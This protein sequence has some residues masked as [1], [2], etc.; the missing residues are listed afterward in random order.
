MARFARLIA[1]A[2]PLLYLS[3]ANCTRAEGQPD[4]E[5]ET[6]IGINKEP[7]RVFSVP[8]GTRDEAKSAA[9]RESSQ[10]RLLNGAWKFRYSKRPEDR[11]AEFYRT[12]FDTSDW[13]DIQVPG[14][15]QTQGYG[16]PIYTNI[17]YPFKRDWP[18]VTGEP[19]HDWTAFEARNP[20][21]SYVRQFELPDAWHDD[22]VFIHFAGVES[23]FYLWINGQRVGY[24]QGSYTPAEF[25]IGKYLRPGV[26]T[27]AVEVYRWCDGSYLEDQDFW[28][29]SGIFRDVFLYRTPEVRLQDYRLRYDFDAPLKD[30]ALALDATVQN[31]AKVQ[32]TAKITAEL[33]DADGTVVWKAQ[34]PEIE[35][36]P[37]EHRAVTLEGQLKDVKKWTGE[38]PNRYQL[39]ITLTDRNGNE[40]VAHRHT[41]GFRKIEF[42]DRG[43]LLVNGKPVIIKGVNRHEH[44][45]DR[46]R[47]VSAE[48][49]LR[50]IELFKQLNVNAVR[51]SHYPNHPDWYEL[52][53]RY[54]IYVIDEANIESH[55]YGYGRESLA[56]VPSYKQAHVDRCQRMVLRDRN[57]PSIVFWSLGNEAG[58]GENFVAAAKRVRELDDT[59][60]V[61][62]ERA[63]F[64]AEST[65]MDSVMYPA[66]DWLLERGREDNSRPFFMCEYAHA[67]GNAI[68]NLDEYLQA[69]EEHPRLIGGC[70]WDWVDQGLR[71]PNPNG[72][73]A[74]NGRADFFAYGG[75]FG[76]RPNDSNFCI[77]GVVTPDRTVTAKSLQVKHSYQPARIE[78]SDGALTIRNEFSHTDLRDRCEL[79]WTVSRDGD[80][81]AAGVAALPSIAPWS[82][83]QIPLDLPDLPP[84]PGSDLRLGVRLQLR[85]DQA[86]LPKGHVVA[87]EQFQLPSPAKSEIDPAQLASV[88]VTQSTENKGEVQVAGEGFT[89]TVSASGQLSELVYAGRTVFAGEAGFVPN[90]YRAP[91]DNDGPFRGVWRTA[92]LERLVPSDGESMRSSVRIT[93]QTDHL[94]Q[95]TVDRRDG[96]EGFY[97]DSSIAY[98]FLGDG[99]LLVDAVVSPSDDA[100]VLPRVGLTATLDASLSR[101]AYY[102]RGPAENYRDRKTGQVIGRY[103]TD[104]EDFYEDYVRPQSMGNRCDVQWVALRNQQGDGVLI[105][106]MSPLSF[107]ALRFTEQALNA[108][109]HDYGLAESEGVVLSLDGAHTGLGGASC[110]P[111][112]L[113]QYTHRGPAR[114]R[115]CV[116]PLQR[117]DDPAIKARST[118]AVGP[119]A[120]FTRSP[121]GQLQFDDASP[122]DVAVAI[123]GQSVERSPAGLEIGE[124]GSVTASPVT[125]DVDS[126]PAV[127]T[128]RMLARTFDRSAW[129]VSVS[130]DDTDGPAADLI[131]G[132]P[133]TFW[134]SRW[135]NDSP[136]PPHEAV[137][138]FG[139]PFR[140]SG[141]KVAPRLN[142]SNGRVR[143]YRIEAS[144]D[145]NSWRTVATGE[146]AD[147]EEPSLISFS[148]E[149]EVRFLRFVA[150]SSY[151]G[152]WASMAE[153]EPVISGKHSPSTPGSSN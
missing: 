5:N 112:P 4:W 123:D 18:Q 132:N 58:F 67:M 30:V 78:F 38:S 95:V 37:G 135:R 77:N 121:G 105:D 52:C 84:V 107:T 17:T 110:G 129:T 114:V 53:D 126:I 27:I 59:R 73:L 63:P 103:E 54:G 19:P 11:P 80:E 48:L 10:V 55:G 72:R 45:P 106:A 75:D 130:S 122:S 25:Q 41:V 90:L 88:R 50:D 36:Q 81:V 62:Y 76:D 144:E 8:Y 137:I 69:V 28:R 98:T 16:T 44:D 120:L 9:W 57:H 94:V 12:D 15:W 111:P 70:I 14:N 124:G 49:M 86:P 23:A 43:E 140:L 108:A 141:V 92:G 64:G 31:L 127:A 119:S 128:T 47:T 7:G 82:T 85:E 113:E 33:L 125:G 117:E 96:G 83:A 74:P 91:V 146:L 101:V 102:G 104:V 116:R 6:V 1:I 22:N 131:D 153:I 29:L 115:F 39:L 21:G 60:P 136:S 51:T 56:H 118:F 40:T 152:P 133:Q 20:V 97:V 65:D 42:S 13:D 68:G 150:L 24:S 139:Q 35:T 147:R 143:G 100:L 93:R 87:Y 71:Q 2:L 66:V 89:A 148:K 145:G 99:T 149:Q 3:A 61:H 34:S 46:G 142:N 32:A 109:K 138:D 26:N 134:H 79:V 151:H